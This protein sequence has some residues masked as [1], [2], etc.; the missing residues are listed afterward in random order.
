MYVMVEKT[1]KK[2][3]VEIINNNSKL[4][5]FKMLHKHIN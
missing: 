1:K 5:D 3:L 2:D 4:S